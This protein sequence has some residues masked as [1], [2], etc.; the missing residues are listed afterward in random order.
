M[1]A[2][3]MRKSAKVLCFQWANGQ[4]LFSKF[5]TAFSGRI[6]VQEMGLKTQIEWTETTWNPL[7]GC[8]KISPGCKF[9]YADRL[10]KRLK[11]MGQKNY[12]ERL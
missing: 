11:L 5:V 6:L 3:G 12:Q 2:H 4:N 10:A 7:T 9:C 8:I 1:R